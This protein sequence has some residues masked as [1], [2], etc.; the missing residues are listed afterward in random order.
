MSCGISV[1]KEI[2]ASIAGVTGAILGD[3]RS[4]LTVRTLQDRW[5]SP[6]RDQ[7]G[8]LFFKRAKLESIFKTYR[9]FVLHEFTQEAS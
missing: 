3:Q 1:V 5:L 2:N 4:C 8:V 6:Q 9:A 7:Q